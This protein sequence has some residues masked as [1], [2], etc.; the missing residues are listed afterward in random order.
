MVILAGFG[1]FGLFSYDVF[2]ALLLGKVPFGAFYWHL[3]EVIKRC[4]LPVMAVVFPF[5][6]V[7]ALQGLG[8]FTMYGGQR[9]LSPF[10]TIAI[11]RELSP[12]M[13]SVLVAAQGGASHAAEL[14]AMRIK[15][16]IDATD[17]MAVDSIRW[18]AAPR[19]FSLMVAAPVLNILGSV[20]GLL[21]G[22]ISAVFLQK[23]PYGIYIAEAWNLASPVDI[24][25]TIIKTTM[26]GLVI[27]LIS[28]Y[29]GY[30]ASGGAAGVGKAVNNTVVFSLLAFM[31]IN[32]LLTSVFYGVG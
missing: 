10:V 14:G 12:V 28:C 20:S 27:G 19:V 31:A 23:E 21:G 3:T 7:M 9:L 13:A 8:I 6:M 15:E 17:V 11:M 5:G 32:Y 30:N 18:H 1:R 29:L 25:A 4:I 24:W 16:Q 2:R 22:F 26:F